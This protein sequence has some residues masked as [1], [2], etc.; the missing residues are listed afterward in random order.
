MV[1]MDFI[2]MILLKLLIINDRV[3]AGFCSHARSIELFIESVNNSSFVC[4]ECE[5]W[6]KFQLRLCAYNRKYVFNAENVTEGMRGSCMAATSLEAPYLLL[7][8]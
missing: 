6:A 3:N 5:S 1:V 4:V 7:N 2:L 8:V